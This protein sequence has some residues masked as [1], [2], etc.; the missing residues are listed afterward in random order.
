MADIVSYSFGHPVTPCQDLAVIFLTS[1][2]K[3]H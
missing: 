2:P 1:H 3:A